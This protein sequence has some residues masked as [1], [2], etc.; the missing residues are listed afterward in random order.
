MIN[1]KHLDVLL[2]GPISHTSSQYMDFAEI[3]NVS[4]DLVVFLLLLYMDLTILY[5]IASC[6]GCNAW[7]RRHL[8]NVEHLAVLLAGPI[9]RTGTQ[10]MDFVEIFNVSTGFL[11]YLFY[12]YQGVLSFPCV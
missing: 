7:G 12:S 9:S 11:Y 8:L 1:P 2:A 5:L 3:F 6:D 4:L 10:Y